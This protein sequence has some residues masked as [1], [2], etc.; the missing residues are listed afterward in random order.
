MDK[1]TEAI[2]FATGIHLKQC[3][4]GTDIPYVTH[5][6]SVGNIL[7]Q[8]KYSKDA[9]VAGI[10]H[11]TLEDGPL[12]TGKTREDILCEIKE[13]FG[14]RVAGIVEGVSEPDPEGPWIERKTH[15]IDF[16]KKADMETVCVACADKLDNI[17]SIK[18]DLTE[19]SGDEE[20][21]WKR[22]NQPK[23]KQKWYYQSLVKVFL[24]RADG[25]G[26]LLFEEFAKEVEL[27]FGK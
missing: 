12:Y 19:H 14:D 27:V 15:T 5:P 7:K 6:V 1:I 21:L 10:L 25:K 4:K 23:E 22:F 26:V 20:K 18:R 16:L 13:R 24:G 17:R 8:H 11:D 2:E 9:I 3:R